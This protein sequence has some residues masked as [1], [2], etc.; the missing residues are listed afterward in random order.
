M[1]LRTG[2]VAFAVGAV[3]LTVGSLPK[4]FPSTP[5][6]TMEGPPP[7]SCQP[8]SY[9][10]TVFF[11][12]STF[13]G[14]A[15]IAVSLA[16]LALSVSQPR[17]SQAV[18]PN[19]SGL[20]QVLGGFLASGSIFLAMFVVILGALFGEVQSSNSTLLWVGVMYAPYLVLGAASYA[21]NHRAF[22]LT[23]ILL[24]LIAAFVFS[25]FVYGISGSF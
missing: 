11:F 9:S 10:A 20:W 21:K 23:L 3:V 2:V 17:I 12:A 24:G 22:G 8:F 1:R 25:G 13:I 15:V 18:K 16:S 4:L 19:K 5:C 7:P 14:M 6:G